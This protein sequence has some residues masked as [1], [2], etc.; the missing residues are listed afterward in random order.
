MISGELAKQISSETRQPHRIILALLQD[1]AEVTDYMDP[2]YPKDLLVTD[3]RANELKLY[4]VDDI[5]DAL[6][7][8][9]DSR[10][11]VTRDDP[12]TGHQR[13]GLK[14]LVERAEEFYLDLKDQVD[15]KAEACGLSAIWKQGSGWR[16]VDGS[17]TTVAE[18]PMWVLNDY[19]DAPTRLGPDR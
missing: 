7:D 2:L 19:L 15:E 3:M 18:G 14:E 4:P 1:A 8:L 12:Q 10:I 13:Y 17:G 6:A 11:V 5:N 16:L 9:R